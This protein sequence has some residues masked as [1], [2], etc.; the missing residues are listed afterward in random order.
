[1]RVH[2]EHLIISQ[3]MAAL[4]FRKQPAAMI[5]VK[6]APDRD[7]I[8]RDLTSNSADRLTTKSSYLFEHRHATR[9]MTMLRQK[10]RE[11]LGWEDDDEIVHHRLIQRLYHI[12]PD[13]RTL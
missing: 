2:Q 1:M 11:R 13:R 9:Q 5:P 6:R 12:Q 8:N 3:E 4:P 10:C 7:A